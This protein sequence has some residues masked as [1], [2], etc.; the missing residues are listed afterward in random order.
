LEKLNKYISSITYQHPIESQFQ[1]N[2]IDNLNAEICLGTVTNV[3]E[4]V[5]WL[6]YT[7][8][9]VRMLKNP[10][11]YGVTINEDDP[12][13]VEVRRKLIEEAAR[14]LFLSNMIVYDSNTGTLAS[15]DIG[16]IA[17]NYYIKNVTME[18]ICQ[19]LKSNM[20]DKELLDVLS[21]CAEFS[22]IKLR[23]EE[24]SELKK[25][26][27][28][29]CPCPIRSTTIDDSPTK[30]N[31]LL[32]AFISNASITE[33]SLVSD[34]NYVAQ[35]S[36]RI[37]RAMFELSVMRGFCVAAEGLLDLCKSLEQ[38]K[39]PFNHPLGQFSNLP[40]EVVEK[41]N[42]TG[43]V[44]D[45]LREMTGSDIGRLIRYQNFGDKILQCAVE[46]PML[47]IDVSVAPIMATVIEVKIELHCDFEWNKQFH[48]ATQAWWLWIKDRDGNLFHSEKVVIP[49]SKYHEAV[50]VDVKL[51]VSSPPP[52]QLFVRWMSDYWLGCESEEAVTLDKLILPDLY[53]PFTDL[54][55][56]CPLP[57]SALRNGPLEA[58]YR[59]KFNFFN[60]I[61]TQIFFSL[62]HCR[63][64]SLIGA[65]TGSGKTIAGELA[66]WSTFRDFPKA[67]VVYIAPLKALVRERVED[68][69]KKFESVNLKI[70][71]LTGDVSPD[72]E[73][74]NA[75]N[76]VITTPEKWDV[77]SRGWKTRNH[78]QGVR[79]VI[80]DEIHL[81]GGDR[82]PILEVI[83][84]R[85]RYISETT[86]NNIRIIGLSTA[87]A[88]ARDLADWLGVKSAFLFNFRHSVRPVQLETYIDGFPGKNYCPRMATMNRPCYAAILRHSPTKPAIIFVS[89][90]RQT[91]LTAL[92]LISYCCNEEKHHQFLH[93]SQVELEDTLAYVSDKNLAHTLS[94][95][96]GMHHAGLTNNDRRLVEHLF[97]AQKIQVLVATSTLAWGVNT[98]AHLVCI[99]GTEVSN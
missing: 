40:F 65:P 88:N 51:P 80:I 62:Y 12:G 29:S 96:I 42:G 55:N 41:L 61:Q 2:L 68:W 70:V 5:A 97:V 49:F 36:I 35:N 37:L 43:M 95:G 32:Q 9:Y 52:S 20:V 7:Y 6:G 58:I 77:V 34:S 53:S 47:Y 4:G 79:C 84:S 87:L 64:N 72:I 25:L 48:G 50:I 66:M 69:Q 39:W 93:M 56:L 11:K 60:A 74:I 86:G 16:R 17:S 81:L 18:H 78:V 63:E 99:K 14:S 67:K 82:G 76:V 3:E 28:S 90:R 15:K 22:Q 46:F 1:S 91:R 54:L 83:V 24:L 94:F 19:K 23:D 10:Y 27:Q 75:C 59:Q 98:P 8:L 38:R 21:S 85:T 30:V 31:I 44:V 33:F 26:R 71:E 92:D 57:V 73:S 89:S 13:L 45:E